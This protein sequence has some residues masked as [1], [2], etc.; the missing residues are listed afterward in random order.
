[1]EVLKD[2]LFYSS[3]K[4]GQDAEV[5]DDRRLLLQEQKSCRA[6]ARKLSLETNQRRKAQE[7]KRR[8]WDVQEEILRENILQQRKQRL[9]EAT[10]RFQRAHLPPSQKRRPASGKGATNL[11]EAL[12]HIH[13]ALSSYAYQS[14]FLSSAPNL[15]RGGSPSLKPPGGS[16]G[17]RNTR[18]LS[19]AEAYAKLVQ[20]R[21]LVDF[22]SSQLHFLNQP[23]KV[24]PPVKDLEQ[25]RPQEH[26]DAVFSC[27]E[28]LSS[29][30]SLE[31]VPE[32]VQQVHND[33]PTFCSS[34]SLGVQE[35][36]E[37]KR[38]SS[39]PPRSFLEKV[40]SQ[41]SNPSSSPPSSV[42]KNE[43]SDEEQSIQDLTHA[44]EH[45]GL[46]EQSQGHNMQAT[47]SCYQNLAANTGHMT[48]CYG[49]A[50]QGN[51]VRDKGAVVTHCKTQT[52]PDTTPLEFSRL[53]QESDPS[54]LM[55]ALEGKHVK[56]PPETD[57]ACKCR[58]RED[59]FRVSSS[60]AA[61]QNA[62]RNPALQK[63]A[64]DGSSQ[65]HKSEPDG[66]AIIPMREARLQSNV[67]VWKRG[68][69]L[70]PGDE[71]SDG[72]VTE[73][74]IPESSSTTE[75]PEKMP[76]EP[77]ATRQAPRSG[78]VRFLK[79]ILKKQSKYVARNVKFSYRPGHF[80]F[81]RQ[82][83]MSIRDSMELARA[84][85]RDPGSNKGPKKKLRWFDEVNSN[86]EED[87]E[88]VKKNSNKPPATKNQLPP[89]QQPL[90][91]HLQGLYWSAYANVPTHTPKT[92]MT[93]HGPV[94][95]RQAW[96]DGGS[97]EG[98]RQEQAESRP[99]RAAPR[100]APPR[101]PRRVRSSHI[102]RARRGAVIRPQSTSEAR[103]VI[104]AQGLTMV[105]RPPPRS[106][107]AEDSSNKAPIN[108]ARMG[109]SEDPP[110]GKSG[111]A[112]EEV[113][114]KDSPDS[115]PL[116]P[117]QI[118][119][120][121]GGTQFSTMPSSYAY[122]YETVAKGVYT[123]FQANAK[124][125]GAKSGPPH[126]ENSICLDRTPTD[127]EISLLWHGVRS[128]LASKDGETRSFLTNSSLSA[129][130]Q[131]HA[132]LSHVAINGVKAVTRIGGVFLNPSNTRSPVKR[133]TV[134]NNMIKSRTH[135]DHGRIYAATPGPKSQCFHQATELVSG[136]KTDQ[137]LHDEVV[138]ETGGQGVL[139]TS[140]EPQ[141][142]NA[143]Q[144]PWGK[145]FG[146]SA[147]SLEEQ[148]LLQSLDRLNE[149]LQNVQDVA[150]GNTALK[151]VFALDAAYNQS[152]QTG[153]ALGVTLRRYRVGSADSRSGSH[154]RY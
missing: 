16:N 67:K 10:E 86:E 90:G 7:E 3:I 41:Q 26:H 70:V 133:P 128:A 32:V 49:R 72:Q 50:A 141:R 68:D 23:Q 6:R 125:G 144:Q 80:V 103:H 148:R 22:K 101:V 43:S 60:I 2:H 30:D 104:G 134:E 124:G 78:D 15:S 93:S 42:L 40:L 138:L 64:I 73:A 149:R 55:K 52:T 151:G 11:D 111:L 19:A 44:V 150:T 31:P 123:L 47:P 146:L 118:F 74:S 77:V 61:D 35:V 116:P 109:Y 46:V 147:L 142:T 75:E 113:A 54:L 57:A 39:P 53:I 130:P 115:Q 88:R 81:T 143:V 34:S 79:G 120:T 17:S 1:M 102:Y 58:N 48:S 139:D 89:P 76:T 131:A 95:T 59:L 140:A 117:R 69:S 14:S 24:E 127:E 84:K 153:E 18:A 96:S 20:E 126:R 56:P 85:V 137:T 63:V 29:L 45:C 36:H 27:T 12:S 112:S 66:E 82:V 132:S 62:Q 98:G 83:A 107:L 154:R 9:Q 152:P 33:N 25:A 136:Y 38:P 114:R 87:E 121:E 51:I 97:Q 99:Q 8:Q 21:N 135:V 108:I 110:A 145:A 4:S 91:D 92:S 122:T 129:S 13:G 37:A 28:S 65:S 119:H 5:E 105:P 106:E 94:S 71:S 100:A